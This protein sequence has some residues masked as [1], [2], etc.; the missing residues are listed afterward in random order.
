LSLPV[1]AKGLAEARSAL[2]AWLERS[3]VDGR[4]VG[5]ILIAGNEACMNAVE[6]SGA[7]ADTK[8]E[9]SASLDGARLS[10]E[11]K[12]RGSWH[13]PVPTG[14]R[15]HGLGL[16]R[17]LMDVVEI[18]RARDGTRVLM[19]RAVSF[20]AT[21]ER[22]PK[23]ASV[24][25]N[26]VNGVCVASLDGDVDLAVIDRLG[27]ALDGTSG[28][29]VPSLVVDL[30]GVTYL[31]SAGVHMLFKLAHRRHATGGATRLAVAAGPVR[32]VLELTG[33]EATLAMDPSVDEAI[34]RL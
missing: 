29:A 21:A 2:A 18:D 16:M 15:G 22:R 7:G 30:T 3:G 31:D 20:G 9:V 6:H 26:E 17:T 34:G 4:D 10:L 23:P 5:D 14:D 32:R 11:V 27:D 13:E 12:D 24:A 8:I 33:V 28:S 19:G 1:E 25:V